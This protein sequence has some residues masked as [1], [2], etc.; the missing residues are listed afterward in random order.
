MIMVAAPF[1]SGSAGRSGVRHV[2]AQQIRADEDDPAGAGQQREVFEQARGGRPPDR[3]RVQAVGDA[4][5]DGEDDDEGTGRPGSG[6]PIGRSFRPAALA[7]R[8]GPHVA[9]SRLDMVP[10]AG[11]RGQRG[12]SAGRDP[13]DRSDAGDA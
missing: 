11:R 7:S 4:G 13:H 5:R 9:T 3:E 6:P 12:T 2:A 8:I 10:V 1:V